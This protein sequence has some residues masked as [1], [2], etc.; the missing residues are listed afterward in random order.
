MLD[1]SGGGV[2]KGLNE[3][4]ILAELTN[5]EEDVFTGKKLPLC[6][7]SDVKSNR[8]TSPGKENAEPFYKE[9]RNSR[10]VKGKCNVRMLNE[11]P[12]KLTDYDDYE[13]AEGD[14]SKEREKHKSSTKS[15][16]KISKRSSVVEVLNDRSPS[17]TDSEDDNEDGV[18]ERKQPRVGKRSRV[19]KTKS[20]FTVKDLTK[21]NKLNIKRKCNITI[22]N[23]TPA[24]INDLI[25]TESDIKCDGGECSN[26]NNNVIEKSKLTLIWFRWMVLG[27]EKS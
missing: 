11:T 27:R 18:K 8:N 20:K 22:Q 3:A 21:S 10:R 1:Q 14:G 9:S 19:K 25:A 12:A 23:E 15:Q 7:E 6:K 13:E 26:R 4:E 17:L 16:V 2:V 24:E 5:E